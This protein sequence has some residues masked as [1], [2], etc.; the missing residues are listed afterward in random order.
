VALLDRAAALQD[1]N[2]LRC[3]LAWTRAARGRA[4]AVAGDAAG[5][6]RETARAA[7]EFAAM[8]MRA[9]AAAIAGR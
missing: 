2:G 7:A 4:L 8:G 1:G 6:A 9:A 5:A 3:D